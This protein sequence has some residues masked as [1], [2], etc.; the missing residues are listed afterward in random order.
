MCFFFFFIERWETVMMSTIAGGGTNSDGREVTMTVQER[1]KTD[2]E[3]TGM[4]G[5]KDRCGEDCLSVC[6]DS[7]KPNADIISLVF[8][9]WVTEF[10]CFCHVFSE[11]GTGAGNGVAEES[12][13]IM[14]EVVGR[15]SPRPGMTW[16]LSKSAWEETGEITCNTKP[17]SCDWYLLLCK[18]FYLL[19]AGMTMVEILTVGDTTWVMVV[20]EGP[21]LAHRST[22]AI[23]I[24]TSCSLI[25]ASPFR[26]GERCNPQ[27]W[28]WA[29]KLDVVL[30]I[31]KD[32]AGT[33][34]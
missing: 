32:S 5:K 9:H 16:V 24:C 18:L 6:Q 11:S 30:H 2:A 28:A 7:V 8:S 26:R 15:D 13:G 33:F 21:A 34:Q 10:W 20:E 19:L 17:Q 22:G 27:W 4:T 31:F 14:T 3:M 25:M 23:L 29:L 12:T 1:E